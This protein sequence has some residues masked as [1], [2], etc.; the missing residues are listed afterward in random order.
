MSSA[1]VSSGPLPPGFRKLQRN[2]TVQTNDQWRQNL[3]RETGSLASLWTACV[4]AGKAP[5]LD[6][7]R[8]PEPLKPSEPSIMEARRVEHRATLAL[9]RNVPIDEVPEVSP[10]TIWEL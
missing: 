5:V 6:F 2:D 10:A 8:P 3:L 4:L 9:Q 1:G 7:P